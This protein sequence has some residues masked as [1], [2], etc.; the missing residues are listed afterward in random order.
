MGIWAA[1][2]P[3]SLEA[4]TMQGIEKGID[5][6]KQVH[7]CWR[8]LANEE[9]GQDQQDRKDEQD[10]LDNGWLLL[11]NERDHQGVRS[12]DPRPPAP[13]VA[14]QPSKSTSRNPYPACVREWTPEKGSTSKT[15]DLL[16]VRLGGSSAISDVR[17]RSWTY[18]PRY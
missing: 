13:K 9:L 10:E 7:E 1:I 5:N 14:L 15:E 2:D 4:D 12:S 11:A 8:T 6:V 18:R 3:Q 17:N 16:T